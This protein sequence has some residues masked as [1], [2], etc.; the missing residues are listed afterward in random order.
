MKLFDENGNE[1]EAYTAD[2]LKNKEQEAI[3]NYIA[4][5]PD[6]SE[7]LNTAKKDLEEANKKIK[8][9]EESGDGNQQQ[10]QRL[11]QQKKDAESN[12]ETVTA[13]LTKQINDLQDGM[14]SGAKSR[15]LDKLS[16]GDVELRKKIEL[17]Y[18]E[19][20]EGKKKPANDVE[21]QQ[22]LEKAYLLATGD[23]P[24]PNFMDNMNNGAGRGEAEPG[25]DTNTEESDNSKAMRKVFGISDE[26]AQK[27]GS[28][29]N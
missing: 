1:V 8:E 18:D 14:I 13:T 16:N 20:N 15:V 2:E 26:D 10:K 12:L 22:R 7:E 17:E 9:F 25:S 24:A 3:N 6:K 19:Y 29:N 11:I 27:Y 23:K 28:K 5:N 21:V 4:E